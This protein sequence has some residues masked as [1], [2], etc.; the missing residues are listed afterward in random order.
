MNG[1]AIE[2]IQPLSCLLCPL[3]VNMTPRYEK[4]ECLA[5]ETLTLISGSRGVSQGH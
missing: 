3:P 4:Q 5:R 2:G 1:S